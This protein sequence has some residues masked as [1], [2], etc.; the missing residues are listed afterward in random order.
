MG[1]GFLGVFSGLWDTFRRYDVC[2]RDDEGG[3]HSSLLLLVS[4]PLL[5]FF[6]SSGLNDG[7]RFDPLFLDAAALVGHGLCRKDLRSGSHLRVLHILDCPA[8]GMWH[9]RP[10]DGCL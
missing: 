2:G 7:L 5:V 1:F 8:L 4:L 6:V 9:V 3:S 10:W